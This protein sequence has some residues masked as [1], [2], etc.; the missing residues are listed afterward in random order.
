MPEEN[1][2]DY[3]LG[4][5]LS[6]LVDET[7]EE[8]ELLKL[9]QELDGNPDAQSHYLR[10]LDL[11]SELDQNSGEFKAPETS[12]HSKRFPWL[13]V[14]IA[15]LAAVI[16][17]T[18]IALFQDIDESLPI[19]QVVAS[20]G[21]VEWEGWNGETNSGPLSGT[22]LSPGTIE[23]LAA[24]SWIEFSFPDGTTASL[25][26]TS[27][28][29][30]SKT[31][32]RKVLRLRNGNLS[33]NAKK[34]PPGFPMQVITPSAEAEVLG[35]QFNVTVD[36]FTTQLVV[37]EGLVRVTRL[38]DGRTEEVSANQEVVAS[39]ENDTGFSATNRSGYVEAWKSELPRDLLQGKWAHPSPDSPGGGVAS[40][41]IWKGDQHE[42]SKPILLYTVV[43][44]P[45]S[46]RL[47][48]VQIT[49]GISFRIRGRLAR[50][51]PIH[52][53]FATNRI[54]GGFGGK[55][56]LKQGSEIELNKDGSFDLEIPL[57]AFTRTN[58][59]F[60]KSP[61][62]QEI[63][64]FWIQTVKVDAGLVIESVKL[65]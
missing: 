36:P 49:E 48:P 55:Y 23:T 63:V 30:I 31:D 13:P 9:E 54:K 61:I 39:L 24:E 4:S 1:S 21:P 40:P 6:K 42:P 53:G 27:T 45:S 3:R 11:H 35:T 32:G 8:E 44:N 10:Y 51:Y 20:G 46:G 2:K 60:P 5:L 47:P 19:V 62:R 56:S 41:H 59:R 29:N 25:S 28:L 57:T 12:T 22:G 43:V 16:A 34:Q 14:A 37:N 58:D 18:G 17:I 64:Y 38:A 65:K 50:P 7:I 33:I 52:C 15:S 26:G